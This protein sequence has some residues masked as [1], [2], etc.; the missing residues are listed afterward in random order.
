MNIFEGLFGGGDAYETE[1][2]GVPQVASD[3]NATIRIPRSKAMKGGPMSFSKD[4]KTI[5]LNIPPGIAGGKKL[6]L[7]RQGN[8][9]PCCNH[10]GD[11][12]LTV[13]VD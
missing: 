4:G 11:L 12:I 13:Q 10:P 6:R 5:T 9:C 8:L 1:E 7:A 2:A 3:V